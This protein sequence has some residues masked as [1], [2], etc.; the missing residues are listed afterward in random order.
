[1]FVK[2]LKKKLANNSSLIFWILLVF[3]CRKKKVE[4]FYFLWS[5]SDT[6]LVYAEKKNWTKQGTSMED[7]LKMK[8]ELNDMLLYV[9]LLIV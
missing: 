7:F 6:N 2:Y 4:S 1:M 9:C 8:P 3:L 5:L